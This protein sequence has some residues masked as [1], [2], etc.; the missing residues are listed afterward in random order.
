MTLDDAVAYGLSSGPGPPPSAGSRSHARDRAYPL[1]VREREVTTLVA[2]G[3]TNRQIAERLVISE[4]T[5][6]AHV[7]NILAKLDFTSRAEVGVWA[8]EHGLPVARPGNVESR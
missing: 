6:D 2:Q 3:L 8:V 5:A 4:R 7:R 1:T